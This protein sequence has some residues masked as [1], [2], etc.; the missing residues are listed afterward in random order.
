MDEKQLLQML[1]T[2]GTKDLI[3]ISDFKS[4]FADIFPEYQ[5]RRQD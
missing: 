1:F 4:A 5:Y 2:T 3:S